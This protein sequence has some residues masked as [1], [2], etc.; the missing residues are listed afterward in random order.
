MSR[1][2]QNWC[3]YVGNQNVCK[4]K[5]YSKKYKYFPIFEPDYSKICWIEKE[6]IKPENYWIDKNEKY[7]LYSMP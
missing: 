5:Q 2:N 4:N 7:I 1:R 3:F 6:G